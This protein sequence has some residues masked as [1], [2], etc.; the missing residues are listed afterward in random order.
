MVGI[1]LLPHKP[2]AL[3]E[4]M[5]KENLN[6]RT[7][8]DDGAISRKWN[9]PATPAFYVIDH[10]GVIR[11]KWIGHPGEKSIDAALEKLIQEAE[12]KNTPK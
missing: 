12:G 2:E 10:K 6:W 3:K 7:F 4:V 8:A 1:N 5:E 11:H 9:S